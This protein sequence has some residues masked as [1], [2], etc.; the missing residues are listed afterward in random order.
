MVKKKRK[1]TYNGRG[2]TNPLKLHYT[3]E[4]KPYWNSSVQ[5]KTCLTF[6]NTVMVLHVFYSASFS[7]PFMLI[8]TRAAVR[9]SAYKNSNLLSKANGY[10]CCSFLNHFFSVIPK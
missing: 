4:R 2:K 10:L 5:V 1:V 7:P 6:S 8:Q 3:T 9:T